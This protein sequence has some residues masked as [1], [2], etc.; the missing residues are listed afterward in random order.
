MKRLILFLVALTVSVNLS[1]QYNGYYSPY[2]QE[3][4]PGYYAYGYVPFDY[5]TGLMIYGSRYRKAASQ[6]YW[7]LAAM[8]FG[9][10][11]GIAMAVFGYG[12]NE[13]NEMMGES[14]GGGDAMI[15]LGAIVTA[16]SLWG[17]ISLW[18]AGQKEI[19]AMMDDYNARYAPKPYGSSLKAGATRSGVGL[20]LNF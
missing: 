4:Y 12:E 18:R 13:S 16:A 6:T 14:R 20:A 10:A 15:V 5:E 1:A 17:G 11:T 3:P 7:G 19:D 8:T 2:P 9:P